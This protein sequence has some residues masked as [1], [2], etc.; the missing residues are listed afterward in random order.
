MIPISNAHAL[1]EDFRSSVS[2]QHGQTALRRGQ[3]KQWNVKYWDIC[4][5]IILMYDYEIFLLNN[6]FFETNKS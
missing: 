2:A 3:N 1:K 5:S 4:L 6:Q